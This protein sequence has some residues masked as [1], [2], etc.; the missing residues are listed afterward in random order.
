MPRLQALYPRWLIQPHSRTA[1]EQHALIIRENR[2]HD[3]LPA[4]AARVQYQDADA[5][6]LPE[7]A[8]LPGLINLHC[9]AAMTLLRGYADDLVLMDWLQQH[10]WPAE[11]RHVSDEFVFDGTQLA[12]TELIA[13]GVTCTNDMYFH[14]DAVARAAIDAH[15]RMVV[16]CSILEF[17]TPY[18][19][20]ADAYISK[21]LTCRDQFA[22]EQLVSFTLAPHAPYTV[23]DAT[24]R[25]VITLADELGMGIHCHIHETQ[26]EIAGSLN[27]HG[28]RPLERLARLGL[29]GSQLVAAHM[30]HVT[31]AEMDL[32]A[33]HG[34]SVAHNPASNLKL[35]SGF[36]PVAALQ[37]HGVNVGLGTDGAASNNKLD[38]FA[39]L[40]LAALL[41][42]ATD[43]NPTALPAWDALQMATNN[44]AA[45][46]GL[47]DQ[48]GSLLPG[49]QADVIAVSLA[50]SGAQP[51]YD[52]VSQLVYATDRSQVSDVWIAGR[53]V[54]AEHQHTG[55]IATRALA[56]AQ[57]WQAR[58]IANRDAADRTIA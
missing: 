45:A 26:D 43:H 9:H 29:L 18:A 53:R 52:P 30:V 32:L 23:S 47:Q 44:G 4:A 54:F 19:S 34:V 27:E 14:H 11:A 40:R 13:G 5:V 8:L 10:I 41:A 56:A 58:I 46:L 55:P 21:A 35:A 12:I 1:L 48:I 51:C 28:V 49:L 24:F 7:H 57:R 6:S 22:G 2:I 25:R 37:R 33:R 39:D 15:Y 42:K 16:G 50:A 20:D 38:L 17:P 3:I 31:D 36:A